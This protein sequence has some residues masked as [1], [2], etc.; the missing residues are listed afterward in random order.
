[1]FGMYGM[2]GMDSDGWSWMVC[3]VVRLNVGMV[4]MLDGSLSPLRLVPAPF[5]H[6]S[7]TQEIDQLGSKG[8][9]EES[10]GIRC[11]MSR[12]GPVLWSKRSNSHPKD[13]IYQTGQR[14][15]YSFVTVQP[16]YVHESIYLSM[17]LLILSNSN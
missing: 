11:K 2:L 17:Y 8:T 5:Q 13:Q 3:M 14:T 12:D 10:A 15:Y 4:C 9:D 16:V 1:M 7:A 6:P